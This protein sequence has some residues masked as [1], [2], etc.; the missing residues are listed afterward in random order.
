MDIPAAHQGVLWVREK[1]EPTL[2]IWGLGL[3]KVWGVMVFVGNSEFA[4]Y[5]LGLP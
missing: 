3:P 4:F 1:G 2:Y 5:L